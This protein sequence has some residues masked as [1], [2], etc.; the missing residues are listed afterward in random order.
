[1]SEVARYL[2]T[3]ADERTWK[4]DRPVIFLGEWWS[5]ERVQG[6]IKEFCE[7]YARISKTPTKDL[8]SI[9]LEATKP[10]RD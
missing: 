7:N 10:T 5:S 8:K 9:L 2:I 3:N 6:A 1:M 4:F